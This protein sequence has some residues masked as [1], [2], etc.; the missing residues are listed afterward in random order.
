MKTLDRRA[1]RTELVRN[2][3][4]NA[5]RAAAPKATPADKRPRTVTL[6]G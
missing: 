5:R 1:I 6:Y 4:D 2:L 3:R